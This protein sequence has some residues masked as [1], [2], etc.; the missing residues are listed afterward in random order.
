MTV[1]W[2]RA[3]KHIMQS[4]TKW[5][6]ECFVDLFRQHVTISQKIDK[7]YGLYCRPPNTK[8]ENV[9]KK[10]KLK[11]NC[12]K[13]NA[14]KWLNTH[15]DQN[16]RCSACKYSVSYFRGRMS[17]WKSNT[18]RSTDMWDLE[19]RY[20]A[21]TPKCA[22]IIIGVIMTTDDK[23]IGRLELVSSKMEISQM[24]SQYIS[25]QSVCHRLD[26]IWIWIYA[27]PP[28]RSP[29]SIGQ[30][31]SVNGRKYYQSKSL[32]TFLFDLHS[33]NTHHRS[34]FPV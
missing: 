30:P 2:C 26:I 8:S 22:N 14:A 4:V 20:V 23:Y 25:V 33:V 19:K 15:K 21:E 28:I 10:I 13:P 27:P 1:G 7:T 18:W 12:C 5:K 16:F 29:S 11:A 17:L 32:P 3:L 34:I 6:K 9:S 24:T 31:K